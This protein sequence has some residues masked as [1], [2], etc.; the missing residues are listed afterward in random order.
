MA[1]SRFRLRFE[2]LI[3]FQKQTLVR[4]VHWIGDHAL[5]SVFRMVIS[6]K[7]L[8]VRWRNCVGLVDF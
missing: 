7:S 6:M 4:I 2:V 8:S 3:Q 1:E 5:D